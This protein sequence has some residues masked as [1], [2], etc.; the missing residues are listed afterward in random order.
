MM[1]GVGVQG[2]YRLTRRWELELTVSQTDG[3]GQEGGGGFGTVGEPLQMHRQL[4]QLTAGALFH[5]NSSTEWDATVAAGL[6]AARDTI[7]VHY[8]GFGSQNLMMFRQRVAYLGAGL[9][10]RFAN[11]G[12]AAQFR[13]VEL[14][15]DSEALDGPAFTG[16]DGPVPREATE[17]QLNLMATYYF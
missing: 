4:T 14:K 11:W 8:P 6:G 15:R 10:R 7:W 12:L 5:L 17:G 13:V 1:V 16:F 3:V 9:E 2:R